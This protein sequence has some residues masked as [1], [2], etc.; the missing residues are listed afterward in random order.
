MESDKFPEIKIFE[1]LKVLR[2]IGHVAYN[3][4][5]QYRVEEPANRGASPALDT[6]LYQQ[7]ELELRYGT[8]H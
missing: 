7:Q 8:Q 6:Q 4:V 2:A 1:P 5:S 3:L